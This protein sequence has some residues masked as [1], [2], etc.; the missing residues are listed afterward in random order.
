VRLILTCNLP[1]LQDDAQV[2]RDVV[3]GERLPRPHWQGD[4][5]PDDLWAV[6]QRCWEAVPASRP[7]FAQLG[8]LLG[9]VVGPA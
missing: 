7:T 6:L 4:A 9:A 8:N 5:C 2:A 1:R 3:G